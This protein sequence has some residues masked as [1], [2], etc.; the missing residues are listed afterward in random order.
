[1]RSLSYVRFINTF[2]VN[3]GFERYFEALNI[4]DINLD[5]VFMMQTNIGCMVP[6]IPR[7]DINR[8]LPQVYEKTFAFFKESTKKLN[9]FRLDQGH[10]CL[11]IVGRRL[12]SLTEVH[13]DQN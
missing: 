4:P 1:M 10:F 13:R 11:D 2:T 7:M 9:S 5:A 6:L 8:Y 3:K 12:F